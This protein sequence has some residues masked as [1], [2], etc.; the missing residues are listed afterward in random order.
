MFVLLCIKQYREV[1][2]VDK[3]NTDYSMSVME[4][5]YC[6]WW[7]VISRA[8]HVFKTNRSVKYL[9]Y[10]S[11]ALSQRKTFLSSTFRANTST[12]SKS[13]RNIFWHKTPWTRLTYPRGTLTSWT[14]PRRGCP[15]PASVASTSSAREMDRTKMSKKVQLNV[16]RKKW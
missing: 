11:S 3:I 1:L 9:Q 4:N 2:V 15:P 8:C 10:K 14:A 12:N 7:P 13:K 5:I 16:T 6:L